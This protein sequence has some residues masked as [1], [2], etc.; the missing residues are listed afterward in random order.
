MDEAVDEVG[1]QEAEQKL[2]A[3]WGRESDEAAQAQKSVAEV[4]V[5]H[6]RESFQ[7]KGPG[8]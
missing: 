7:L 5:N 6:E 2:R 3:V 4:L 8:Y 1:Y